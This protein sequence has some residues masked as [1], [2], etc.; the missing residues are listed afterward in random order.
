MS[1]P[2]P[3]TMCVEPDLELAPANAGPPMSALAVNPSTGVL[4]TVTSAEPLVTGPVLVVA[5]TVCAGVPL[6]GA[7]YRPLVEIVAPGALPP[8]DHANAGCAVIACPN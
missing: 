6:D 5:M 2:P 4:L 8:I 3:R 1:A 7:V